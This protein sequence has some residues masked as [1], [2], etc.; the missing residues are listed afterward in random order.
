M[1]AAPLSA[2]TPRCRSLQVGGR[3]SNDQQQ[4]IERLGL[5]RFVRTAPLADE[6]TLRRAYREWSGADEASQA[7]PLDQRS[8]EH[9]SELQS[10][11]YLVCRLVLEKKKVT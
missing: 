3:F 11:Q 5:R 6:S 4:L 10:R 9:T 8:E 2:D 1:P 7:Q